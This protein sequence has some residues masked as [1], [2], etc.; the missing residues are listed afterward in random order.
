MF[1]NLLVN[2]PPVVWKGFKSD[3]RLYVRTLELL[4]FEVIRSFNLLRP[5]LNIRDF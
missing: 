4:Y 5:H 3:V 1:T 2:H